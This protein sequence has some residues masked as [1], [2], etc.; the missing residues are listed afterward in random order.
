MGSIARPRW[1]SGGVIVLLVLLAA[2]SGYL[3]RDQLSQQPLLRPWAEAGCALV[4][5]ALP[6]FSDRDAFQV[7]DWG[8]DPHP[9]RADVFRLEGDLVNTAR[10]RQAFPKLQ[11]RITDMD[12]HPVGERRFRA[13]EYLHPAE[14]GAAGLASG[15]SVRL[16]LELMMPADRVPSIEL[17]FH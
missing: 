17:G 10:F 1:L 14:P 12:G 3:Y 15:Q 6:P 5:C 7:R 13:T 2:Q 8:F 9:R 4:G 11:V 16:R